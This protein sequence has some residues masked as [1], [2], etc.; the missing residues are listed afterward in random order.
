MS[1]LR[2]I[3]RRFF[4]RRRSIQYLREKDYHQYP[5]SAGGKNVKLENSNCHAFSSI[6]N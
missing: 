4:G 3:G 2:R 6:I 1:P 5:N